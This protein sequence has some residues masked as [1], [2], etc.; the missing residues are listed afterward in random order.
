MSELALVTLAKTSDAREIAQM[1][2]ELIEEGL[3]WSWRP[4]RVARFIAD[5]DSSVILTRRD[6]RIAGFALMHF[7]DTSA[8][9][10][11]LAVTPDSRRQGLGRQ[12]LDWLLASALEAGI[13]DVNL[14]VRSSNAAALAFYETLGFRRQGVLP[15]YYQNRESALV[16]SRSL[17]RLT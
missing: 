17:G 5:R 11:L 10:N 4:A 1:S 3:S 13:G 14:E 9:L 8:H 2:R 15:G 16:M 12:L 7:G 6:G